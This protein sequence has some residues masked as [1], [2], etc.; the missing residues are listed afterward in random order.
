LLQRNQGRRRRASNLAKTVYPNGLETSYT[1]DS[2][3]RLTGEIIAGAQ[4]SI[5][6]SFDAVGNRLSRNLTV[7]GLSSESYGYDANDRLTSEAYDVFGNLIQRTGTTPNLYLYA[8]EQYDPD[9]GYIYL[10][11]R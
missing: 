5:G 3:N 11:A 9:I 4:G 7:V 10:R 6:Y 8:G 1:Y 2:L